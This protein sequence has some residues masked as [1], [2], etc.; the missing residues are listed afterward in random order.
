MANAAGYRLRISH[1]PY[2]SSLLL[3]R[4]MEAPSVVVTGLPVGAY[5]WSIESYDAAGK[6]SVESEK[7]R[8]TIV[9]KAKEKIDLSL[10]MDPLIQ[11]GHVIEV[12]GKTEAGAR[13][14]V[15]GREVPLVSDDGTFHY[16]TPPLPNGENLITVTAQNSKGGVNTHQEKVVIQ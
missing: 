9:V 14:M 15:N 3:D 12:T 1:N 16:F 11:H 8:F 13:V 4:K 5:Y 7:N 10:D 6:E 2:F